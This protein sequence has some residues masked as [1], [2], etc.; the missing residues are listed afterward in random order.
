[1]NRLR[2]ELLVELRLQVST[3]SM[4]ATRS[5]AETSFIPE[6]GGSRTCSQGATC[7]TG[8]ANASASTFSVNVHPGTTGPIP[9]PATWGMMILG[10]GVIGAAMRRRSYRASIYFG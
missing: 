2:G 9:E 1:M 3:S 4:M 6:A 10:F 7:F 5:M 8:V